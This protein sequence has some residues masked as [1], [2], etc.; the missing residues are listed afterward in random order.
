MKR[1]EW[2]SGLIGSEVRSLECGTGDER[3]LHGSIEADEQRDEAGDLGV[4]TCA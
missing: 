4:D 1:E 3:V 2:I